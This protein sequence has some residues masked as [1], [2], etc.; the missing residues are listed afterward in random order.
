MIFGADNK[1]DSTTSC[2]SLRGDAVEFRRASNGQAQTDALACEVASI[3]PTA[4]ES[5]SE[6]FTAERCTHRQAQ[7]TLRAALKRIS[8]ELNSPISISRKKTL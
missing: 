6:L 2:I 3:Q 1:E 5:G 4:E 7:S 8:S